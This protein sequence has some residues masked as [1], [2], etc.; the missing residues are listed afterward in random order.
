MRILDLRPRTVRLMSHLWGR[1]APV[2]GR[3]TDLPGSGHLAAR[4]TARLADGFIARRVAAL[5]LVEPGPTIIS[6]GNLALGGTGKTPVVAA[7]ADELA[8]AGWK[9]AVLTRGFG[10]SLAGPLTVAADNVLAGD[11]ARLMAAA[12]AARDW[13]VIQARR[14]ALGLEITWSF[15]T[16]NTMD[17]AFCSA[18]IFTVPPSSVAS[19]ALMTILVSTLRQR[20]MSV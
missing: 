13:P 1:G 15:Q 4:W 10:S 6:I 11:E 2:R 12:L 9:G 7:L 5:R 20:A 18:R 8:V 14:R 19:R 3:C 17:P 16:E